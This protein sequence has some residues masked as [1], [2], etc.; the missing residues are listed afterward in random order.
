MEIAGRE[1]MRVWLSKV[2]VALVVS[3]LLLPDVSHA[4]TVYQKALAGLK[5]VEVVVENGFRDRAPGPNRRPDLGRHR[6]EVPE[7]WS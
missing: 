3:F 4:L 2:V 6:A 5:G 1:N 7:S